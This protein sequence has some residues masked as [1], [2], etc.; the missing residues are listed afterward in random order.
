MNSIEYEYKYLS[1]MIY[2]L[3]ENMN[4]EK[5]DDYM[6]ACEGSR[7]F[8]LNYPVKNITKRNKRIL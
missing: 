8:I 6:L 4:I 1:F 5:F 2:N 3:K 7:N